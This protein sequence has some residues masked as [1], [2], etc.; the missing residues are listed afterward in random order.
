ME[1]TN[2]S[3]DQGRFGNFNANNGSEEELGWP[4]TILSFCIPLAGAIMFF[5]YKDSAPAKSKRACYAALA[6]FGLGV[7]A[8]IVS[9]IITAAAH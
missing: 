1:E 4:L 3:Q 6:G 5:M 2:N 8:N 7:I 9:Y